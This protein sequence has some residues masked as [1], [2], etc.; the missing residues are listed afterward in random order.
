MNINNLPPNRFTVSGTEGDDL[1]YSSMWQ[2]STYD[3]EILNA[4]YSQYEFHKFIEEVHIGKSLDLIDYSEN[5]NHDKVSFSD[6]RQRVFT[7]VTPINTDLSIQL[8][9]V[10]NGSDLSTAM[11]EI[12][13][14][15]S[16]ATISGASVFTIKAL[17]QTQNNSS[18]LEAIILEKDTDIFG[19]KI[20]SSYVDVTTSLNNTFIKI[21]A[22]DAHAIQ[23][24]IKVSQIRNSIINI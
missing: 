9:Q 8:D 18:E 2:Y 4:I 15:G 19:T 1:T 23:W 14:I 6:E 22:D 3:T 20:G 17:V 24:T 21:T 5:S 16:S 13:A 10:G 11:Y 7:R 12:K